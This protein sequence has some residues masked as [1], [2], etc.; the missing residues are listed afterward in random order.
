MASRRR[1][2]SAAA[3]T[4]VFLLSMLSLGGLVHAA[5]GTADNVVGQIDFF[6]SGLNFIDGRGLSFPDGI[7]IDPVGGEVYVADYQN[8][9]VLGWKSAT[10]FAGNQSADLVIGQ[11]DLYASYCNRIPGAG[12]HSSAT[13]TPNQNTLCGPEG[14]AVKCLCCGRR[15]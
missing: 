12:P 13:G 4:I 10:E 11:S 1:I 8:N 15:Q 3:V 14:V 5:G 2:G 6:H 7:A 9:R